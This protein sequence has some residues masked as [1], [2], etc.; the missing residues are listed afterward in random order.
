[1][2]TPP[3]SAAQV[4]DEVKAQAQGFVGSILDF[5]F[6]S[7]VTPKIIKLVYFI[8]LAGVALAAFAF[9][10]GNILRGGLGAIIGLIGAPIVLVLGAVLARVYVEIVMLAFKILETLQ[11]IESKE[12]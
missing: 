3:Q 2:D 7:F 9:L 10:V 12:K 6:E 1:M 11:R 4:T 8:M 5:S